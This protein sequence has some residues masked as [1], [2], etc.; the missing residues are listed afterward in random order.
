[1]ICVPGNSGLKWE[2]LEEAHSFRFTIHT[3]ST[4]M[5][6]NMWSYYWWSEIKLEIANFIA[7]CLV[8]ER[9]KAK[10]QGLSRLLQPLLILEWKT[11][12]ICMDLVVGLPMTRSY[13]E[14]TWVIVDK[15]MKSTHFLAKKTNDSLDKLAKLYIKKIIKLN[16]ILISIISN[17]DPRF[18][19]RFCGSF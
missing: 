8:H 14:T 16:G 19:S 12:H 15:L 9:I 6:Q 10:Y 5:Y 1:M 2:I 3:D 13:H 17:R 11:E 7:R 4:K 18:M